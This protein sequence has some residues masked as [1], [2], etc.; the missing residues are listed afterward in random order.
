MDGNTATSP[1][2]APEVDGFARTVIAWHARHGRHDLPWQNPATPYRVWVSEIML[3]Q[4]QVATVIPYFQR[5]MARFPTLA[6]LAGAE[7][8]EVLHLW[9]GLGY[10]ARARHLHQAARR[11]DIDHGG[12]FPSAI[13]RLLELPGIGRSTAGA[14]LSLALGQRHPILDGNVKRVLARYHAIPG[15]PARA[16]V[17]RRLWALAEHHT[18]RQRNAAYN[19][20]LMDLGASLCIRVRPRCGRCP[21]AAG[22]AARRLDRQSQFPE[23]RPARVKPVRRTRMLLLQRADRVL[24]VRRPPA[25]VWGGLWCPP[26]CDLEADYVALCRRQ[27]GLRIGPARAWPMRRHTFSHFHLEIHPLYASVQS[28]DPG[29]MD[30]PGHLWYNEHSSNRCGLAA[31]VRQLLQ[32]LQEMRA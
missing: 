32:D 20:G 21:L 15:W 25:G 17:Q 7:I 27:F 1:T 2:S 16:E 18:P 11:I 10:Y 24:L 13:D 29:V 22:C 23:P 30:R 12:R 3:Q 26:E 31:P 28:E 19:Q 8:D 5:F 6:A 4:T 14:I 9:T